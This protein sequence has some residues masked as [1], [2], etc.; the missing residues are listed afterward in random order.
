MKNLAGDKD[1]D[2]FVERELLRCGIEIVRDQE[3]RGEVPASITGK[4]GRFT[5]RRAWYYWVVNGFVPLA[6]AEKLYAHPVGREDIRVDGDCTCPHP[7]E[8]AKYY[9]ADG[10]H[11]LG[12]DQKPTSEQLALEGLSGEI[13]RKIQAEYVFAETPALVAHTSG[14]D[15][16][17]I[18]SE[19]G[20][21]IFTH[22]V[23]GL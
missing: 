2:R 1:C 16:Y 18:D 19:L 23:Y 14:V 15:L 4:L 11:I 10:K 9:C 12:L 21:Y 6:V 13:Y 7:A 20:L 3:R 17:H 22:A 5:F 8:R